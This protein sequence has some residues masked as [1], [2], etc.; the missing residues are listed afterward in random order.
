MTKPVATVLTISGVVF[1]VVF[2]TLLLAK[3]NSAI[4]SGAA[5]AAGLIMLVVGIVGLIRG[6]R[7]PN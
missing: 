6:R 2:V 4:V 3:P 1:L 5:S 7:T